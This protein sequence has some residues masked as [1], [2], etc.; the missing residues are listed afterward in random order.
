MRR[1]LNGGCWARHARSTE[2]NADARS[3][4]VRT[5]GVPGLARNL[6]MR[7]VRSAAIRCRCF[8]QRAGNGDAVHRRV[9]WRLASQ[10]LEARRRVGRVGSKQSQQSS[11]L[12]SRQPHGWTIA[13]PYDYQRMSVLPRMAR[14]PLQARRGPPG[15]LSSR[16]G[17]GMR[18]R[19]VFFHAGGR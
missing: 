7:G 15:N 4:G 14:A 9:G 17:R 1:V 13:A 19:W 11:I 12:R 18:Y 5:G 8:R 16:I 2:H 6:P 10:L 3:Q